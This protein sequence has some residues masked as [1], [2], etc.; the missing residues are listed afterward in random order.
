MGLTARCK[1]GSMSQ[2]K[3]Y[4]MKG[5]FRWLLISA[6]LVTVVVIS[7]RLVHAGVNCYDMGDCTVCIFYDDETGAYKGYMTDCPMYPGE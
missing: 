7:A 6:I 5:R 4:V 1:N 2:R 3:G